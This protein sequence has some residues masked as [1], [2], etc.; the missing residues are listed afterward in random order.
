MYVIKFNG[1]EIYSSFVDGDVRCYCNS[2]DKINKRKPKVFKTKK[3]AENH[4]NKLKS[5]ETRFFY[6]HDFK[7]EEWTDK[8]LENHMKSIGI[9]RYLR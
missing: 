5:H 9:E 1:N 7:I 8:D 3:G 4:M 6:N 2:S